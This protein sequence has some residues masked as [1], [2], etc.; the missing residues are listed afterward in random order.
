MLVLVQWTAHLLASLG[1]FAVFAVLLAEAMGVPSPSEIVLL[2]SGL[3]V[4]EGRFNF[5]AVVFTGA[6]GSLTGAM[7]AY[8]L[9]RAKGRA[10]VERRLAFVFHNPAH[11]LAL[12]R[13][14]LRYGGPV[15]VAGRVLTGVRLVIAYPAGLFR[16][17]VLP[18]AAYS[19]IGALIW[20]ILGVGA[21]WY[22]GPRVMAALKA[23]H[24]GEDWALAG[25]VVAG[26]GLWLWHRHR[27]RPSLPVGQAP[28]ASEEGES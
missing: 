2:L 15:V 13:L 22:L 1:L 25:L 26:A 16:M 6:A 10:F 5:L 8:Q 18:F 3:L 20:P 11:W 7:L 9:A 27:T 14:F 19:A 21:G 4:A 17:P 12:E 28:S 23:L 24:Q